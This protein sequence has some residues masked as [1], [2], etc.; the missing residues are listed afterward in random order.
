M[1]A[2]PSKIVSAPDTATSSA[3]SLLGKGSTSK[4]SA[5]KPKYVVE[6]PQIIH[7]AAERATIVQ[8]TEN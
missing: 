5:E 4:G 2:E 1:M 3:A 7:Q 8:L 6:P